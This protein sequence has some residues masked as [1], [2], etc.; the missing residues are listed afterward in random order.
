MPGFH[1]IVVQRTVGIDADNFYVGIFFFQEFSHAADGSAR[2]DAANEVRDLALAVLPNFRTCGAVVR[3]GVHRIVVL[4][5]IVRIGN[6]AREF[7]RHRIIAARIFGLDSG[8]TNDYFGPKRFEQIHFF[9]GLLVGGGKNAFV[10]AHS[11]D[12]R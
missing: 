11:R 6:F 12:Q 9:L 2:A 8:G 7:F 5:R 3:F 4:V 10:A 1:E